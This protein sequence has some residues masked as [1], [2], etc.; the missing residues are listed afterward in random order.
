MKYEEKQEMQYCSGDRQAAWH[1][2]KTMAGINQFTNQIKETHQG[3]VGVGDSDL[4]DIFNSFYALE[5][6]RSLNMLQFVE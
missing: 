4:L 5:G 2:I 1:E 3:K 6:Q